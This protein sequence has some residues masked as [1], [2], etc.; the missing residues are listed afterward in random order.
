MGP[1]I[2]LIP[3][4]LWWIIYSVILFSPSFYSFA[5]PLS[6]AFFL[7]KHPPSIMEGS[8]GWG[9]PMHHLSTS[10]PPP[11]PFPAFLFPLF[12][13]LNQS[14]GW[15][16]VTVWWLHP[17]PHPHP[18]FWPPPHLPQVTLL[19]TAVSGG[20]NCFSIYF[21]TGYSLCWFHRKIFLCVCV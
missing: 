20:V 7:P 12:P 1:S 15:R 8:P 4:P 19:N 2:R 16:M 14:S 21:S 11:S 13:P 10:P 6:N 17:T 3:F 5:V 18:D 9:P